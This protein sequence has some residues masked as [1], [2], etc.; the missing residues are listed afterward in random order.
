[1]ITLSKDEQLEFMWQRVMDGGAWKYWAGRTEVV[2]DIEAA[3]RLLLEDGTEAQLN[4]FQAAISLAIYQDNSALKHV[5]GG[6]L[7]GLL[8]KHYSQITEYEFEST[9]G[10]DRGCAA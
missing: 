8:E 5:I 9:Y 4:A 10:D 7:E 6:V 2:I 3:V 1:M